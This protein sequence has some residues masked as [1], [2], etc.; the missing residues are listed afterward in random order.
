M[1]VFVGNSRAAV[2]IVT[3]AGPRFGTLV[4]DFNVVFEYITQAFANASMLGRAGFAAAASLS[5]TRHAG[6]RGGAYP[7]ILALDCIGCAS[8]GGSRK[9]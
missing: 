2:K 1:T 8:H 7:R 6:G 4:G 9:R 5:L 3:V